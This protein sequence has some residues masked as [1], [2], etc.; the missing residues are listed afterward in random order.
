MKKSLFFILL[1]GFWPGIYAQNPLGID[2]SHHQGSINWTAVYADGK[3]FAFV[4]ATEGVTYND[5]RFVANMTNGTHA[6]VLMGAYHFARPDNNSAQAEARH[7]LQVAGPYIGNGYLPPVLD[8]EDPNENTDLQQLFSSDELS[9]WV[10]TW[11]QIVED[12][13][14]VT[15]IIYTNGRYTRYL[16]SSLN[17][18]PLWIAEPDGNL[19]PPDNLGRWTTWLFK[20]YSWHGNVNG[21]N[22]DVDLDVFNGTM[23]ELDS[24]SHG[25]HPGGGGGG[26]SATLDCSEAVSV[27]CGDFYHGPAST[28]SSRVYS[29]GCNGWTETGPERVHSFTPTSATQLQVIISGFTGDLDAYILSDCDPAQCIAD[30]YSSSAVTP[31]LEGGH[32]YYIVVDADDGS[33]SAYDLYVHC[34]SGTPGDDISL[35]NA[36]VDTTQAIE[37]GDTIALRVK[38][39]YAGA[40]SEVPAVQVGYF[41]STDCQWDDNDVYLGSDESHIHASHRTETEEHRAVIPSDT[42][43]GDYYILFVADYTGQVTE[44]TDL[45]NTL[46]IPVHIQGIDVEKYTLNPFIRIYPNPVRD[47]LHIRTRQNI[48]LRQAAVLS[49]TGQVIFE[50]PYRREQPVDVSRL[51]PGM[52]YLLLED[53]QG[54]KALIRFLKN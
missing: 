19:D 23:A 40:A 2:V 3:T 30:V 27:Q 7:F 15:P 8:L 39:Y 28:D 16:N 34:Y 51:Q 46:C 6:G 41:L 18:Y 32:T 49:F 4:K 50:I 42:P 13:T 37:A 43:E 35:N 11:L 29:Y 22:G 52:Y 9:Q 21:I 17:R 53:D 38:Q 12:S 25:G 45:N 24:L 36:S 33:G 31:Q 26:G 1:W 48:D 20:Q 54:R 14:G 5:P 44:I 10:Q 47:R